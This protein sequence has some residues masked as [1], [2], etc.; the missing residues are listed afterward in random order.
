MMIGPSEKLITVL[1]DLVSAYNDSQE[2]LSLDNR[3]RS[4]HVI[5]L[6]N[7]VIPGKFWY[8]RRCKCVLLMADELTKHHL[9]LLV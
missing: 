2:S 7:E 4:D 3:S 6:S 1:W 8:S 5:H 9:N